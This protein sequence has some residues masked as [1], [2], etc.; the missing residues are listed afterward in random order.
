[1][2]KLS[3][4]IFALGELRHETE[5]NCLLTLYYAN[6]YSILK[7]GI[8]CWGNSI[9]SHRVFVLQK[10]AVRTMLFVKMYKSFKPMYQHLGI[11][12]FPCIYIYEC[13]LFVKRH[14]SRFR[15]HEHSYSIMLHVTAI[16]ISP[17][18]I[19]GYKCI[20]RVHSCLV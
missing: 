17:Q 12:P 8:I 6:F 7:S 15:E 5:I 4:V 1:M 9:D 20:E 13:A 11:L 2:Q 18:S 3:S 16:L 19:A 14:E 10:R